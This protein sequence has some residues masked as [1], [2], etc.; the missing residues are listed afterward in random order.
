MLT[1]LDLQEL[2]D[3]RSTDPVLSV[4]L[5]VDPKDGSADVYKLH[6]RQMLKD[7]EADSPQDTDTIRRFI[8]HQY[9]W[10][11]RGLAIFSCAPQDFFRHFSLSI[12]IRS[13]A[14][15]L[16][17]PY[18]KPLVDVL[19][20]YGHY[21]VALVDRQGA[22]LFYF[23]MGQLQEQEGTL[24]E[25]VRHT[26]RGGGSQA[27]GRRGGTAGL[28]RYSEEVAER[29]LKEAARFAARFF[30]DNHVRRI[31]VGGT[32]ASVAY[33]L[34]QLPKSWRSLVMGTFPIEMTAGH[35]Q[36]LE[37][38]LEVA[39]LSEEEIK[40]RLVNAVIT[41][42]AK[43]REGIIG[44]DETL[45]AV[46][47]GRVQILLINEGFRALGFRCM[48]CGYVSAHAPEKCPFC[49][50]EFEQIEDAVELV[51]RKVLEDGG[52]VEVIYENPDLERAGN[53]GGLLRY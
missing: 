34:S 47:A 52:E 35:T 41:A 25:S 4:Y 22:R 19:N 8:E 10:S 53:I 18:V 32:E 43:G 1:E 16:S 11:G 36:V 2:I 39:Q 28:T 30:R 20:N 14:R 49:H 45:G 44:L 37:K 51:V 6:L 7:F 33:F 9:D 29:N 23:H 48:G 27:P 31:L 46:H 42:A 17:H 12:P 26:K 38:A 15:L 24:G 13:R 21:G 40:S 3:Y 5:N 50:N